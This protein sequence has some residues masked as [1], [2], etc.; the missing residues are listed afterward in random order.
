MF[1][2]HH[3]LK[4]VKKTIESFEEIIE[5]IIGLEPSENKV[6]NVRE[7]DK[8]TPEEKI[9]RVKKVKIRKTIKNGLDKLR[10]IKLNEIKN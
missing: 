9:N 4:N 5:I 10:K 7:Y 8:E 6:Y 1:F 3:I 2:L